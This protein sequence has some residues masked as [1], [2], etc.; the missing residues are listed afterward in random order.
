MTPFLYPTSNSAN[1]DAQG[2]KRTHKIRYVEVPAGFG[3][4]WRALKAWGALFPTQPSPKRY[5]GQAEHQRG[6]LC[7]KG[8]AQEAKCLNQIIPAIPGNR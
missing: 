4:A 7:E 3:R 5:S 1:Q 2:A 6:R 8:N